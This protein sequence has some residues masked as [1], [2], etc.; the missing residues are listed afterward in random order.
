VPLAWQPRRIDFWSTLVQFLGTLFFNVMT[1]RALDIA[2]SGRE[3]DYEV[4]RP[5]AF[6]SSCFLIAGY[7]A[8]AEVSHSFWHQRV[9]TL[10]WWIAAAN[11][12]GSVEFGVSALS[13]WEL[14]SGAMLLT[15]MACLGTLVGAVCFFAGAF[16]LLPE[17]ARER[18][19]VPGRLA[20]KR[21]LVR[22]P[23]SRRA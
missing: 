22:V 19:D 23:D 17:A 18:P 6:G 5:D 1:F 7:L 12:L 15:D 11:M 8:G 21:S 4:W 13:A 16:L 3:Y 14:P 9:R 2:L 20:D 10:P